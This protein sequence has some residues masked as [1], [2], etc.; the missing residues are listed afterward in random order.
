M[1]QEEKITKLTDKVAE[2]F[3]HWGPLDAARIER[4]LKTATEGQKKQLFFALW[5]SQLI[6]AQTAIGAFNKSQLTEV[7]RQT[8]LKITKPSGSA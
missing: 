4:L 3:G 1:N 7:I 2:I 6:S 8:L 5:D